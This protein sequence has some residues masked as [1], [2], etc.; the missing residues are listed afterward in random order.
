MMSAVG[1]Y[2]VDGLAVTISLRINVCDRLCQAGLLLNYFCLS[3]IDC[4]DSWL[5]FNG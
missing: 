4:P 3:S 1:G 2:L 5:M